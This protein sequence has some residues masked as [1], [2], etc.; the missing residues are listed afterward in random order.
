MKRGRSQRTK[1]NPGVRSSEVDRLP[2]VSRSRRR[3]DAA[4]CGSRRDFAPGG[5]RGASQ[6]VGR[7]CELDPP[8]RPD[9][10]RAASP[11]MMSGVFVLG[12]LRHVKTV[13][14]KGLVGIDIGAGSTQVRSFR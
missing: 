1:R 2:W 9:L 4:I 11:T 8:I 3:Y 13:T 5:L 14:L 10:R 7:R 6:T 12:S